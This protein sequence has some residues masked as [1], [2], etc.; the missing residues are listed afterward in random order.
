MSKRMITKAQEPYW[1]ELFLRL[2]D[3]IDGP[4]RKEDK[5]LVIYAYH[6]LFEHGGG[7]AIYTDAIGNNPFN[8]LI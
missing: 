5:A 1:R 7:R 6:D 4:H 3:W 2:S 8:D